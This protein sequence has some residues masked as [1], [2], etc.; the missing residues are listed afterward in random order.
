HHGAGLFDVLRAL[1]A[2]WYAV[3]RA[4]GVYADR[5]DFLAAFLRDPQPFVLVGRAVVVACAVASVWLVGTVGTRCFGRA[6]G[7]AGALLLAGTF[8]H[9][10]ES[11]HVWPDVPA[12]AAALVATAAALAA[13]ERTGWRPAALAGAAGG[14]ALAAKHSAFAAALPV[15]LGVALV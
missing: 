8:A 13:S 14:L 5:L 9:V 11:H 10:R 7:I 6:A 12:G 2:C 1:F 15:A 3:G 4:L